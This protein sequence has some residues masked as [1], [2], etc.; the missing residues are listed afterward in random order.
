MF[1]AGA[2]LGT[3]TLFSTGCAHRRAAPPPDRMIISMYSLWDGMGPPN[4]D[5]QFAALGCLGTPTISNRDVNFEPGKSPWCLP[6][7]HQRT[8]GTLG[9]WEISE[10]RV[11]PRPEVLIF[12][13]G[14]TPP[15]L[16]VTDWIGADEFKRIVTDLRNAYHTWKSQHRDGSKR[17]SIRSIPRL[18]S[19]ESL[20]S[21]W[22]R[23]G[24]PARAHGYGQS[25]PA[26]SRSRQLIL[27]QRIAPIRP[28]RV[29]RRHE[30][31][32]ESNCSGEGRDRAVAGW[33][34]S[35]S[36]EQRRQRLVARSTARSVSIDSRHPRFAAQCSGHH[37]FRYTGAARSS[38][39]RSG[40]SIATPAKGTPS[41]D[42]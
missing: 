8:M 12:R 40:S 30:T 39:C 21:N 1:A 41:A 31:I 23:L 10:I 20:G 36:G 3:Q 27:T 15:V 28:G 16:R 38:V 19:V 5:P 33:W 13:T 34:P 14:T 35:N 4:T 22:R 17:I 6:P 18:Q 26:R 2:A 32:R 37:A 11:T 9:Y 29:A 7:I 24:S 25:A 42:I